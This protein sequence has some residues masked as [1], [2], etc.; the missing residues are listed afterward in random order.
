MLNYQVFYSDF[1]V[2][3]TEIILAS[4]KRNTSE[5][6]KAMKIEDEDAHRF[7]SMSP[8]DFVVIF[9]KEAK[10]KLTDREQKLIIDNHLYAQT[11]YLKFISN[12]SREETEAAISPE[13]YSRWE[14]EADEMSLAEYGF[15]FTYKTIRKVIVLGIAA[16]RK[17]YYKQRGLTIDVVKAGLRRYSHRLS[18]IRNKAS[19]KF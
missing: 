1:R 13:M 4:L 10:N 3:E 19:T 2:V 14:M 9:S 7:L 16:T 17:H 8:E 11:Q 18:N 12:V 6:Y 5:D 15:D